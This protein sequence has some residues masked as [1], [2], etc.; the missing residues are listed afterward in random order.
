[1][2]APKNM[3]ATMLHFDFREGGSYRLRLTY[4]DPNDGHGKTSA[5][6]D[7]SEVRFIRL[8]KEKRI[9]QEVTFES[10]DAAFSGV[11]R[12]TWTFEEVKDGTLITVL[13]EDVP[14]GIRPED[15]EAG[16]K[17]TL[18]NLTAFVS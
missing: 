15:H 18:D 1:V 11:M 13:A 3:T 7:E 14:E 12:M 6:G 2:L 16:M 4:K 10:D 17:A 9:E 5:D 8:V